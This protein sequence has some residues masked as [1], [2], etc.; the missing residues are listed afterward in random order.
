MKTFSHVVKSTSFLL[1]REHYYS[2]GTG[3][4]QHIGELSWV[5]SRSFKLVGREKGC[6]S[7]GETVSC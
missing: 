5:L 7:L 3:D 6:Y 2:P 4:A 1:E